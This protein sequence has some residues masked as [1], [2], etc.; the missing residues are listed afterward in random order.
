MK[1]EYLQGQ[2]GFNLVVGDMKSGEVAYTT[3]RDPSSLGPLRLKAG[4]YGI[5]N[6]VLSSKWPKTEK[7]RSQLQVKMPNWC[8]R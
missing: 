7:G 4:V 2:A 3:N 5:S 8:A 6:G 1:V